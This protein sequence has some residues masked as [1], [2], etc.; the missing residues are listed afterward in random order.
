MTQIEKYFFLFIDT[1]YGNFL[2]SFES[3]F[4]FSTLIA[5]DYPKSA[6][7]FISLCATILAGIANYTLGVVAY[8]IFIKNSN[9]GQLKYQ[10]YKQIWEKYHLTFFWL[11]FSSFF[12]KI[13]I[14]LCGLMHFKMPRSLILLILFRGIYYLLFS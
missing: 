11:C 2:L 8:N 5:F 14:T 3:D 6:L 12:A 1:F 9:I 10:H 4:A 13:I 7:L